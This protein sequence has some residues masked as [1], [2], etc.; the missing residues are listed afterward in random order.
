MK[1]KVRKGTHDM[2]SSD[3]LKTSVHGIVGC[4]DN[5]WSNARKVTVTCNPFVPEVQGTATF[6]VTIFVGKWT[7]LQKHVLC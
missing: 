2:I 7:Q 3:K 1:Q 4:P 6:I 5:R